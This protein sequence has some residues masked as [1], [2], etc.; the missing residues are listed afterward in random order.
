MKGVGWVVRKEPLPW[1]RLIRPRPSSSD[2]AW[3][4]VTRLTLYSFTSSVSGGSLS[5]IFHSPAVMRAIRS[6]AI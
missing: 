3:R 2:R 1:I 6:E 5:P 4:I